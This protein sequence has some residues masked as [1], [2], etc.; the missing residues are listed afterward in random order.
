[1]FYLKCEDSE[2][3]GTKGAFTFATFS[4][5]FMLSQQVLLQNFFFITKR[6]SLVQNRP[7]NRTN[8]NDPLQMKGKTF[9]SQTWEQIRKQGLESVK[10]QRHLISWVV[11]KYAQVYLF[12]TNS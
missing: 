10:K 12:F 8:V 5:N 6:A 1:M 4:R 3:Y 11:W 7:R 2:L 9:L